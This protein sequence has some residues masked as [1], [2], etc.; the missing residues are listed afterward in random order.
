MAREME[1]AKIRMQD[2]PL[3]IE[4][5]KQV[6][7]I[8]D[9]AIARDESGDPAAIVTLLISD[10]RRMGLDMIAEHLIEYRSTHISYIASRLN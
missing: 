8:I 2:D 6:R 9:N 5:E 4:A 7:S 3:V 1:S 10:M